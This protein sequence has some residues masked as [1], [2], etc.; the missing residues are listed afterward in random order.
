MVNPHDLAALTAT[1]ELL[2]DEHTSRVWTFGDRI[3]MQFRGDP[4][5]MS[6]A[7]AQHLG[8]EL[9]RAARRMEDTVA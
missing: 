9:T 1:I 2:L 6:I 4:V 5:S 3:I 7:T 8:R